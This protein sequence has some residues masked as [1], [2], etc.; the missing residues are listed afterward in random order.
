MIR[1]PRREV[2]RELARYI[3]ARH[4][5]GLP[6]LLV[7]ICTHNSRRSH[8]AQAAAIAAAECVGV[9]PVLSF[10]GGTEATAFFPSAIK[11]LRAAGFRIEAESS[12]RSRQSTAESGG[13]SRANP[14]YTVRTDEQSQG[15]LFFSKRFD[16]AAN[17][18]S[19][20]AAV[21]TCTDADEACP[22]VAGAGAR[23]RLPYDDPKAFDDTPQADEKYQERLAEITRE[24]LFAMRGIEGGRPA[25]A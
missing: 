20:F 5:S 13:P 6:A 1:E 9:A 4:A 18:A 21:M 11:A 22:V 19:G 14:R 3:S 24:L 8:M 17:P 25:G 23:I 10:S 16:D 12:V 2:L 15:T 7:F